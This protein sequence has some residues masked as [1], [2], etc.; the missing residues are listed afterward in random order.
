MH[1][2][3]TTFDILY[4]GELAVSVNPKYAGE[5][6]QIVKV[7]KAKTRARTADGRIIE[8]VHAFFKTAPEGTVFELKRP[9][10]RV[11]MTVSV[12]S[13]HAKWRARYG[14]D[15]LAHTFVIT[16]HKDGLVRVALLGGE[17]DDYATGWKFAE[18]SVTPR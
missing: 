14:S 7:N 10:L 6:Y 8:A 18:S 9:K 1:A 16:D 12:L 4:P 2:S 11:G 15:P 3:V 17:D 5:V 13:S